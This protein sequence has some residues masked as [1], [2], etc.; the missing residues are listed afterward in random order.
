M[1]LREG[2]TK[3][4]ERMRGAVPQVE[5]QEL[6]CHDCESYVQ[7]DVDL[8]LDGNHV[9][10]CPKCGH[11]HCRVVENGRITDIRWDSRNGPTIWASNTQWTIR[12]NYTTS[13]SGNV[14]LY[15]SWASTGT[16]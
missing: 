4:A 2:F 5:R 10:E 8:S 6:W 15:Q 7:F 3:L 14:F 12:S 9:L 11:E 1:R 13:T 16:V